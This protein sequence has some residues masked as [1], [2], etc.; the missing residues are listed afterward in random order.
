[1]GEIPLPATSER[2]L[3]KGEAKATKSIIREKRRRMFVKLPWGA[4]NGYAPISP[5]SNDP[6]TQY[7]GMLARLLRELPKPREEALV[8]F[9]KFV[10]RF[11]DRFVLTQ[12]LE[13]LTFEEYLAG[14]K[15]YNEQRKAQLREAWEALRGGRPTA[16]QC[17]SIA[18]FIKVE[19]YPAF[20]HARWINSRSDA[21]KAYAA[22]YFK[23]IENL[24]FSL[25]WFIKHTP[26]PDRPAKIVGLRKAGR[27]FFATD[28]KA[29]ESHFTHQIMQAC[30]I[31]L[32]ERC[33]AYSTEGR[34]LSS[35]LCGTRDPS[36]LNNH[37]KTRLGTRAQVRARRMS[38]DLVTSL[39]NG[40][41]NLMLALYQAECKTG[42]WERSIEGYVEGDDGIFA[43]SFEMDA[44]WYEDMGFTIVI[45]EHADPR[46]ASFCGMVFDDS[47]IR[48]PRS[49]LLSFG[50]T[51]SFLG[52]GE[53]LHWSLLRA[54]ALS[55]TY[56][57]PDCPVVAAM[58]HKAL[59][60]TR[61]YLPRWVDDGYHERPRDEKHVRAPSP[62]PAT[63]R[64]FAEM[65]G[66]DEG[67]QLQ[68]EAA[69]RAGRLEEVSRLLPA[70]PD[71][72][73]Y[74][75]LYVVIGT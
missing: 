38:G 52:G 51:S 16:R 7:Q 14:N 57:T 13:G 37:L 65:Y 66:I 44:A 18:S 62:S 34:F 74:S 9:A 54:K 2:S 12:K 64:L 15:S 68:L 58:A 22:C 72:C 45:E 71:S 30:E 32:Y 33:L 59:E 47:I 63:R 6:E 11:I 46:R 17:S 29:F 43:C 23:P 49:F 5:D 36:W 42:N 55:V 75:D 10:D 50:W 69:I 41:T 20:K 53:K 40:F 21:F 35:A 25:P 56:E 8:G 24:V 19:N 61:G 1:M 3:E 31:R 73:R 28:F 67:L 39:G 26:V 4:V 27:R 70:T 60:L 48:D